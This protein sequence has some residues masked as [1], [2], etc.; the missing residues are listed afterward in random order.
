MIAFAV[1]AIYAFAQFGG[2]L[3]VSDN[4]TEILVGACPKM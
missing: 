3:A 1:S 4:L 2:A